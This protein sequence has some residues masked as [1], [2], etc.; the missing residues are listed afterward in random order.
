MRRRPLDRL[1]PRV[2]SSSRRRAAH[3][4]LAASLLALAACSGA[5]DQD[6]LGASG[7]SAGRNDGGSSP[8][9]TSTATSAPPIPE[10]DGGVDASEPST[11]ER[12]TERNDGRDQA[13]E[14]RLA[15]CGELSV[16]D[17]RDYLTFRAPEDATSLRISYEGDVQI[18]VELQRGGKVDLTGGNVPVPLVRGDQYWLEIRP[19]KKSGP[20]AWRVD[21][22]LR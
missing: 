8:T 12:E 14:L 17:D 15:M 11:C 1:P 4:V 21:L 9:P 19:A 6:V 5:S 22:D 3:A 2:S 20:I 16:E 7:A 13:N 10:R 18:E